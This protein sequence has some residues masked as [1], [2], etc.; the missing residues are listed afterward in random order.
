MSV[1]RRSRSGYGRFA[2]L[3]WQ[4]GPGLTAVTAFTVLLSASAPLGLAGVVGAVVG[5]AGDVAAEGLTSSAGRSALWWAA[6]AAG[7]LMVVWVAGSV[8]SAAATALGE[9]I[10]ASLQRE[11][12]RAVEEPVGVGHLEDPRTSELIAVGRETFRGSWG[13]PGRLASTVAGLVTGRV[14]LLGA[15]VLVADFHPLLGIALLA[16]GSWTAYEEK[17]AS[18]AEAAHH[19]GASEVARRLEY[20]YGLGSSPEAAK[21]VRI[22]GLAGF[23]RDRYSTL[24]QRSMADVITPLP[25]RAVAA[26][27]VTAA[28]VVCGLAWIAV[29]AAKGEVSA[30]QAAV[31]AQALMTGL[32]GVHQSA[33]TGLQTEL[34]LATLR[35]FDEAIAAVAAFANDAPTADEPVA[36]E[37]AGGDRPRGEI[38]FE[39]VSFS[40]PGATAPVLVD[41]DLTVPAGRSLAIV[42]MNGA[43]KT[44]IIKLLCR[45]YE[46]MSGRITVEGTDL[47]SVDAPEW[48]RQ[49]A[50]VFQDAT[51][52]PLTARESI[53]MGRPDVPVD[54]AGIESAAERAG[55]ADELEGLPS[56]W[57]TPLSSH[58]PGGA[59]LSGGQWQKLSLARALYAVD[60]GAD[61][62]ILDEP[63]A[64]LDARAE[65]RLY[66]RFLELTAGL[67]TIV[68]SHRFSTVRRAD[69]I[70][71]LD[72]GRVVERGSHDELVALGGR[73][74]EMFRLQAERFSDRTND[75]EG[76]AEVTA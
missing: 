75:S 65:A 29:R 27:V 63:A 6:V 9:R 28:V 59:D 69:V 37:P 76:T 70:V 64:H 24:W 7:L 12:M 62:L 71:V 8:R 49:V 17:V 3:A 72:G 11:L 43:G 21:E 46:P 51:R 45:M 55:V 14:V 50:A 68:I 4:A 1:L 32:L 53:A 52:F 30:G 20:L 39:R 42:G 25:R 2:R 13:R 26:N 10:D 40:Y 33:W 35:R 66:T 41:L 16:A 18:R 23:L 38:R 54:Q 5:L 60:H 31:C 15:C 56:S 47:A 57:D 48:R 73:Y 36:A 74:A 58:Y 61:V 22:F 34:A 67:S 19:Y 44:T